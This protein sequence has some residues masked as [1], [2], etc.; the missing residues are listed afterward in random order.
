MLELGL[1]LF[2]NLTQLDLTGPFDVLARL[3]DSRVH[4][5][6]KS[7]EVVTSDRGLALTPTTSFAEC[8]PLDV[9]LVPG[10]FGVQE[11]LLDAETLAFLRRQAASAQWVTAV[12]TGSLVLGAAGLLD[13]FQATTHWAYT[14]LLTLFGAIATPGRVVVDRNRITGGG[15]TAGIDAALVIAAALFDERVA[16]EI[17][18]NIEYAPEP[19]F[20][21]G[22][23][24]TADA[25]VLR[26]VR[27]ALAPLIAERRA[28]VTR[29]AANV[30][31][32]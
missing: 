2:P 18:L 22:H 7:T 15:V 20:R 30:P 8:P 19:P 4:L 5:V 23:P 27:A 25:D 6:W 31:A 10:G 12:C 29:A 17:Q 13:G 24:D 1:L 32:G 16:K 9:V 11:L 21:C 3:P 28:I 26:D 14:E